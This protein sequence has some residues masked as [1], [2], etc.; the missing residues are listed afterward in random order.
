VLARTERA[1]F[2]AAT[3]GE[4]DVPDGAVSFLRH[5]ESP[6]PLAHLRYAVLALGDR[7]YTHYCAFGHA[8]DG[9]LPRS[10]A[11]PLFDLVEVHDRAA[12]RRWRHELRELTGRRDVPD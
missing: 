7:A 10:G 2:V 8:L 5:L 4:G 1:L 12:L 11:Q 6:A 9:W 3:A